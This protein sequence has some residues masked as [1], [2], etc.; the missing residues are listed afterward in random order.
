MAGARDVACGRPIEHGLSRGVERRGLAIEVGRDRVYDDVE[1][2][3]EYCVAYRHTALMHARNEVQE[4]DFEPRA[5]CACSN[6]HVFKRSDRRAV[7]ESDE[8]AAGI[9]GSFLG[10]KLTEQAFVA[11]RP[12]ALARGRSVVAAK[13]NGA[14]VIGAPHDAAADRGAPQAL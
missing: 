6:D 3:I 14:A 5:T 2:V 13:P 8:C 10:E 12:G 1:H 4:L 9:V 7:G 11:P